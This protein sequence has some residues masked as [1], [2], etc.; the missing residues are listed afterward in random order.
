MVSFRFFSF[1]L[2]TD[3]HELTTLSYRI[4]SLDTIANFYL[5]S[6]GAMYVNCKSLSNAQ[7][8]NASWLLVGSPSGRHSVVGVVVAAESL[9]R[10]R[11]RAGG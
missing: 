3:L 2:V 5:Q 7:T 6:H 8:V 11:D 9:V 10:T 1:Y 4:A